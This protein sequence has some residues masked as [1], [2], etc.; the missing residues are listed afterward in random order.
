MRYRN[1]GRTGVRVSTICL[2]TVYFGTQVA[3]DESVRIIQRALDLGVNFIDTA[4]IYMRPSYGAAEEV[5][6]RALEGRRHEVVLA[7]K[8]RYDPRPHRTGGLGDHGLSRRQIITAVEGSLRRLRTDYIDVYYPH[9]PDPEVDLE[10]TLRAFDDLVRAGK[11]RYIGLSNYPA[12]QV[13]EALWIAD[14]R[15]LEPVA[16]V[17]ALYNL[18]DRE[19][20]R[21]LVPACRRFGLGLMPY[22]P[23]AG[24]VL[25]GKYRSGESRPPESRAAQVGYAGRGRPAHIPVLSERNLAAAGRLAAFASERGETASRLAVAWALHQPLVTA[26]IMGASTVAQIEENVA[27]AD[28]ALTPDDVAAIAALADTR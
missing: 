16:C 19:I 1:L 10:E 22:S 28:L 4:E 6:G 17:Q 5:V 13:V 27:A 21:D 20:E 15:N 14:R 23:L 26:V 11:V 24:G 25:T 8:K 12:W 18:L 7:T 2:G 3:A 9:H